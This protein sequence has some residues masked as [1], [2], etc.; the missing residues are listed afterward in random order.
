VRGTRAPR[1]EQ[2]YR[3]LSRAL[4]GVERSVAVRL[5]NEGHINGEALRQI[6]Y[7]LD[8]GEAKLS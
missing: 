5:R 7:E 1:H 2:R 4:I 3:E 6:E 8:L